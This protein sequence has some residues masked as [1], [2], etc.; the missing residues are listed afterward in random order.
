M[1]RKRPHREVMHRIS[2]EWPAL[3]EPERDE[4]KER[5]RAEAEAQESAREALWYD[6]AKGGADEE[7]PSVAG[8]CSR[9][10][11]HHTS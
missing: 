6:G 3:P 1:K 10:Q 5:A 4:Y 2:I 11:S 7:G 9:Q 8:E